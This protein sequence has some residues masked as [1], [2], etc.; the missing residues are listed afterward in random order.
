MVRNRRSGPA[1]CRLG[2]CGLWRDVCLCSGE[3]DWRQRRRRRAES[4]TSSQFS[5][6]RCL[7]GTGLGV[8]WW[9]TVLGFF[10]KY[11]HHCKIKLRTLVLSSL[12]FFL[13]KTNISE[14]QPVDLAQTNPA[15][16]CPLGSPVRR[17]SL[18]LEGPWWFSYSPGLGG[19]KRGPS[20]AVVWSRAGS[21]THTLRR[22]VGK[23][24]RRRKRGRPWTAHE[25][26][27]GLRLGPHGTWQH[28]RYG[29]RG[30]MGAPRH[31]RAHMLV[32]AAQA[33]DA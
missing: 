22:C 32:V 27:L 11:I 15:F 9:V 20:S 33:H 31:L 2:F 3:S 1:R 8:F 28:G 10:F 21:R 4:S 17:K 30:R 26:L 12:N 13:Y 18:S 14:E 6:R 29:Q 23:P 24:A 7:W 16:R 5:S 19:V 25:H